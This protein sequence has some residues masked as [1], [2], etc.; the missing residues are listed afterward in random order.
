MSCLAVNIHPSIFYTR[1]IQLSS[2]RGAGGCCSCYWVRDGI[3]PG[4]VYHSTEYDQSKEW[5]N[6][7]FILFSLFFETLFRVRHAHTKHNHRSCIENQGHQWGL[8]VGGCYLWTSVSL[9]VAPVH[10]LYLFIHILF[11]LNPIQSPGVP[12]GTRQPISETN[13]TN[14]H[15]LSLVKSIWNHQ[16]T[17]VWTVR[18]SRRTWR[19]P[20]HAWG[21]HA[22]FIQN[23]PNWD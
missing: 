2:C 3:H 22:N 11:L 18:W 21:E 15:A 4:Q 17:Y 20:I 19:E 23:E 9:C 13:W 12:L 16:L 1:V 8:L 14:I 6:F 7:V 5:D 10:R